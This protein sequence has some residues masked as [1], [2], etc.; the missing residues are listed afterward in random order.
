VALADGQVNL[1]WKNWDSE[2]LDDRNGNRLHDQGETFVDLN[3]SGTHDFILERYVDIEASA[4][5]VNWTVLAQG[6]GVGSAAVVPPS[7]TKS[8]F[9]LKTRSEP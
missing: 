4:D 3:R 5:L 2:P 1:S 9:R 6:I 8:F 7:G